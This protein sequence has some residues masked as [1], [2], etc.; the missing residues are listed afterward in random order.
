VNLAFQPAATSNALPAGDPR[1]IRWPALVTTSCLMLAA[2]LALLPWLGSGILLAVG[3]LR[4]PRGIWA[5]LAFLLASATVFAWREIH[6]APRPGP[7]RID[8]GTGLY[9]RAGLF[10][11]GNQLARDRAPGVPVSIIVLE[12]ADLREVH[13]IYGDKMARQVIATLVRK[14][15]AIAGIRGMAGRTDTGQFTIVLPGV[16]G[17]KALR[18]LRRALGKPECVEFDAGGSELVLVPDL[19]VDTADAGA[20]SVEARYHHMCR[21]L[22]RTQKDERRRQHSLTRERERHSRPMV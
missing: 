21:E 9:N 20:E 5:P 13:D 18:A 8:R 16:G 14:V 4:V 19:L 7:A 3:D 2:L 15:E 17:D 22:A 12:F 11:A 1:S 10:A 6:R